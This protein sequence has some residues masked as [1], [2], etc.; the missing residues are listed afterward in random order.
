MTDLDWDLIFKVH[1]KGAY[2]KTKAA[3]PYMRKWNYGRIIVTSSIAGIYG[4]FVTTCTIDQLER[5]FVM[6]RLNMFEITGAKS[7]ICRTSSISIT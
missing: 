6:R 7:P 2:T 5:L 3:W 1:V 4:N